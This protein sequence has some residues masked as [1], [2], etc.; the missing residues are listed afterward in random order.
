MSDPRTPNISL[1]LPVPGERNWDVEVNQNWQ[2]IDTAV[3]QLIAGSS[4]WHFTGAWLPFTNYTINQV[5]TYL[6]GSYLA[7]A[8]FTSGATFG[9]GVGET[10]GQIA[11]PGTSLNFLGAWSNVT[12]YN[13]YDLVTEAGNMYLA[14]LAGTGHDPASSPTFWAL[15]AAAGATGATGSTGAPGATG[16]TGPAGTGASSFNQITAG[17]NQN[18]TLN[19]GN[20]SLLQPQGS[21]VIN[22]NE[23]GGVIAVGGP[24]PALG[25]ILISQGDGTAVWADPLCQGI[26]ADG[27][28]AST[29]N[30]ILVSGKGADNNQHNLKTDNSGVLQVHESGTATVHV[31]ATTLAP[32]AIAGPVQVTDGLNH[33]QPTGDDPAR[34]IHVTL[35]NTPSVT[36]SGGSVNQGTGGGMGA[37]TWTMYLSDGTNAI[38]GTAAHPVV[39]SL[40]SSVSV[41]QTTDPTTLIAVAGKT[42]GG[43]PTYYQI[44]LTSD[45]QA[46][47]VNIHASEITDAAEAATNTT[48]PSKTIWIGGS[49]G[50]KLQGLLVDG[51]GNLKVVASGVTSTQYT[52]SPAVAAGSVVSTLASGYDGANVR[53]LLISNTGVLSVSATGTVTVSGTVTANIG[54]TGG[55]ALDATLTGGTQKTL[56]YD[57]TNTIG[58]AAHPVQVSLANTA[59]NATAVKVDGSAVTQPISGSISFTAP[60]HVIVDSGAGGNSGSANTAT[61]WTNAT[62]LNTTLSLVSNNFTYSTAI[63][64]PVY[65]GT[66]SSGGFNFEGSVDNSTWTPL[67][68]EVFYSSQL[69]QPANGVWNLSS[70]G[71]SVPLKIDISAYPYV[72][73]RLNPVVGGSGSVNVQYT[74]YS[75][76]DAVWIE[77]I[78][79]VTGS[80]SIT[81]APLV[82]QSTSPWVVGGAAASGAA[83]AGNPVQIGGVFNTTQPTVTTG[84]AVEAQSTARGAQ[85]VATGVDTFNVTVSAALP[86]GSAVIGHVITDSGST[87]AVTGTVNVADANLELAQGSTTSGQVGP[88]VQSATT[89]NAPTYTTA[90]TNPLSSDTSGNLRVSLKDS[91]ANTNKFL[92]TPDSVALPANQSVNVSQ[93]N[94]VTPLMGNGVTGTGSPRVT[95]A[96]DNTAFAVNATLSAETTKVIGT[97][98]NVGNIG[99]VYD[100]ATGAAVPANVIYLGANNGGN[101][102]GLVTDA[103]GFLK[104]NVAAGSISGT[105]TPASDGAT[106]SAVPADA[107]YI[108]VNIG[109]NL[110]GITGVNPAGSVY[111]VATAIVD[112]SGNQITSFGGGTQFADNAASGVTPTGTLSM[113]W[114]SANSKV[115]ALKV[116]ASQNL[117]VAVNAALPAGTNVIGHV[118][119]DSGSTTAVTGTVAVT[120]SGTWSVRAQDGAG[121]ALTSNSSTYT[122]KF[123]LDV[124]VL[125]TLG[126]AFSTAGKVDVK[127]ADGDLFVRQATA[128]NLN[129]TA[130]LAAGSA[131]IGHV[132]TDSGSTTAVTGTVTIA[133]AVTEAT[134]DAALISQEATTSGVKGL[135]AFGAV[136]TNAPSYT[137]AKSDALSLDTSGLL[138]VSLKD[139]PANT[140]KFLVTPD[141]VALPAHQSVNVDQL[142]GT[143]TDTDSGNKSAGTLRVVIATDQPALTNKLLVT[144]DANSSVAQGTAAAST[145]SW[146]T[147]TGAPT[148]ANWT[149][150]AITF[151]SSGDNTIVTHTATQ[152]IRVMRIFIVNSDATTATNVTFKDST[153]T[154]FSGAFRLA[155]GGSFAADSDGGEPLFVTASAKDFQINSSAAV[156]IS[157]TIWY[158]TS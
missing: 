89:T 52:G 12:A 155:S 68:Y 115:R 66:V 120:E 32:V 119:T 69:A 61:T 29:I 43:T 53:P 96:S 67:V 41:G 101:L 57:G 145:A 20:G 39:T 140:N 37:N 93:I 65:T 88:L 58:T 84:Q 116:D 42:V 33:Y 122:A 150:A 103:S 157:G 73:I 15:V 135:T 97:V 138:R 102:I 17:T 128:A 85:I 75:A 117:D 23:L 55:L 106:G 118:I 92:V 74:L 11:A 112:G 91:P 146:Y 79:Q 124:N 10:W 125:G 13:P 35:D 143:T 95:I 51:S 7:L 129:C 83:K 94:G 99:G 154:S 133:G 3:G 113:G 153:P 110:R 100:G 31:D 56:I 14:L 45:A 50:T 131:V 44:P 105:F 25:K 63:V 121:N 86:A 22:A 36:L 72:R 137:T 70:S 130:V 80:V 28:A 78:V 81:G 136:T 30:P 98:R 142:N 127:G 134:L 21:G 144:P 107:S 76:Q 62:A 156:Q 64:F 141:S 60:Q 126:T 108:G 18:Q 34:T 9:T 27:T 24:N 38:I 149:Q 48:L 5:V 90:K 6:G 152:T 147:R 26:Q 109:G 47:N 59:A 111:A 151:S 49:D 46:V 40:N 71:T 114:D 158:T 82:Q 87:T 4:N 123:G 16:A 19:V 1:W 148:T 104:V 8:N 132:I 2:L 54:T 77:N 139:T